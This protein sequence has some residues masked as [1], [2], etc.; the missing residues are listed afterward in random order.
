[1]CSNAEIDL[2]MRLLSFDP[3]ER[4]SAEEALNHEHFDEVRDISP[5][6]EAY[7]HLKADVEDLSVN[8]VN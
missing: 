2:I 1:M 3:Q 5:E 4:I 8:P 6:L 7:R